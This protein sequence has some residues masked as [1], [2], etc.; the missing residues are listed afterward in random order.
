MIHDIDEF[1]IV[2]QIG[3]GSFSNVYLCRKEFT[4]ILDSF[5]EDFIIKEININTLVKKYLTNNVSTRIL[6]IKENM[7]KHATKS[8][9]DATVEVN[10]TPYS[11]NR[12]H[13]DTFVR[14]SEDE[15]YTK[16]LRELI[17]S[18]VDILTMIEHENI[19]EFYDCGGRG[20]IYYLC[21]E[22]CDK[23]DVYNFL[24]DKGRQY[25]PYDGICISQ[26]VEFIKQTTAA[27]VYLHDKN[28]IHRDVKLHNILIKSSDSGD[29]YKLSDFGFACHDV[30]VGSFDLTE[31]LS[32]KYFKLCGTP[33]YMAPEIIKNMKFLEDITRY[34]TSNYKEC[35]FYTKAIDIWSYGVCIYELLFNDILFPGVRNI[36][37]LETFFMRTDAQAFIDAKVHRNDKVPAV[38]R[39]LLLKLLVINPDC[40]A[41]ARDINDFINLKENELREA[42][43]DKFESELDISPLVNFTGNVYIE[44]KEALKEHIV[45]NPVQQK[46]YDTVDLHDSWERVNMS[47]SMLNKLSVEKGFLDWLRQKK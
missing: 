11:T 24:K 42:C 1:E 8:P 26:A 37:D 30:T 35:M 23:G 12:Y 29:V 38:L 39:E 14:Q 22:Y 47:S 46:L 21:M 10:I 4:D 34:K 16:R 45:R 33:Y 15:Y 31:T 7:I 32:K 19:I 36:K 43:K 6:G 41:S 17:E 25:N 27:F 18:E 2:K 3:K 13:T 20:D 5:P 9:T 28:I 44:E 40:R